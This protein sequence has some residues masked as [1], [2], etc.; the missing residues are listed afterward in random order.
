M[1]HPDAM[2]P[3]DVVYDNFRSACLWLGS[4][5][6]DKST[7]VR[8][9]EAHPFFTA[10]LTGAHYR[11][12]TADETIVF[13]DVVLELGRY[14]GALV[15]NVENAAR[16]PLVMFTG[17]LVCAC[18]RVACGHVFVRSDA[19]REF[20][21][22]FRIASAFIVS[23]L[24][25]ECGYVLPQGPR[26]V[27][28]DPDFILRPCTRD[29]VSIDWK[30][31]AP[32]A[33]LTLEDYVDWVLEHGP[34][35]AA[36]EGIELKE[37][38]QEVLDDAALS[39][40][41]GL[42]G[43]Q[44]DDA[45]REVLEQVAAMIVADAARTAESTGGRL[46][47]NLGQHI[48]RF[49]RVRE[50]TIDLSE[51][52]GDVVGGAGMSRRHVRMNRLNRQGQP[53][54]PYMRPEGAV[55]IVEDVSGSV[56]DDDLC[57]ARGVAVSIAQDLGYAVYVQQV[58]ADAQGAIIDVSEVAQASAFARQGA[59]G[60]NMRPGIMRF[61]DETSEDTEHAVGAVVVVS[62]GYLGMDSYVGADEVDFD[63]VW[64]FT[65]FLNPF[66]ANV[67]TGRMYHFDADQGTVKPIPSGTGWTKGLN[68]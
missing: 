53:G 38:L 6:E 46:P 30:V 40:D 52:L 41:D 16:L 27:A 9:K 22:A 13:A 3:A 8:L 65:N 32:K 20:P 19:A 23:D 50:V 5:Q 10:L 15:V 34:K 36:A 56:D 29:L 44:V 17:A 57:R 51:V 42:G 68:R 4:M 60:T 28:D 11:E 67:P 7:G 37:L 58:D 24:A 43:D 47:G 55:G 39:P 49:L 35:A 48:E 66:G 45:D 1:I 2:A 31:K 63:V 26:L 54:R 12:T 14:G 33:G 18:L 64:L 61:V 21:E 59:G 62:D 25:R